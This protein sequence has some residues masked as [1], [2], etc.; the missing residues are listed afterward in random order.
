MYTNNLQRFLNLRKISQRKIA[1]LCGAAPSTVQRWCSGY[2][3]PSTIT[4]TKI[5]DALN[6]SVSSIWPNAFGLGDR[7]EDAYN[8]YTDILSTTLH[9]AEDY[10]LFTEFC[11]KR[12]IATVKLQIAERKRMPQASE[13]FDNYVIMDKSQLTMH[14]S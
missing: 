2:C 7:L 6:I 5:A 4:A 13:P 9:Y 3:L 8:W 14:N 12:S 11:T 10:A 1:S